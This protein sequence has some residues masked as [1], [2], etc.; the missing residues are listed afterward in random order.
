MQTYKVKP[1]LKQVMLKEFK[2]LQRNKYIVLLIMGLML[3]SVVVCIW[4]T[5]ATKCDVL[6]RWIAG[7]SL[8]A[9]TPFLFGCL[10]LFF[11]IKNVTCPYTKMSNESIILFDDRLEQKYELKGVQY[12][13]VIPYK[14][15]S[16]IYALYNDTQLVILTNKLVEKKKPTNV[17]GVGDT[18]EIKNVI[19][20]LYRHELLFAFD[21]HVN[22]YETI[23]ENIDK[24]KRRK[25][26]DLVYDYSE[27]V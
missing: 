4:I 18:R 2:K 16:S 9:S 10:L 17:D 26:N 11:Y 23:R 27:D 14:Y 21:D 1:E 22:M 8:M 24:A 3:M 13:Y 12:T 7:S 6:W 20:K 25:A 15:I 19:Q 5:T